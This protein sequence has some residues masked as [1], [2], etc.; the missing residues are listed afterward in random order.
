MKKFLIL[1][2]ICFAQSTFSQNAAQNSKST[3]TVITIDQPAGN[4][5][6]TNNEDN[7]VYNAAGIDVKPDF[8]GG[9]DKFY[10]FVDSNFKTPEGAKNIKGKKIYITFIVEKDGSLSDIKVLR[11]AGYETGTEAIRVLKTCPKWNPGENNGKKIRVL[12]SL[13]ITMK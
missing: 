8:P 6:A 13:P 2:L 10:Q 7:V 4:S 12:Y 9:M 3:E 11:D 5:A 1:V